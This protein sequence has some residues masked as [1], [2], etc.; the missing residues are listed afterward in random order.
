[1]HSEAGAGARA[2][3][4]LTHWVGGQSMDAVG[5]SKRYVDGGVGLEG[6]QG[7][8]VFTAAVRV[9]QHRWPS[10]W[11]YRYTG[12]KGWAR[13]RCWVCVAHD[14]HYAP[15]VTRS[16]PMVSHAGR[17]GRGH[18]RPSSWL[19]ARWLTFKTSITQNKPVRWH[20]KH[21]PSSIVQLSTG[22]GASPWRDSTKSAVDPRARSATPLE[23]AAE[24]TFGETMT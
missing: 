4:V 5:Q 16:I 18:V 1:M 12:F 14:N 21:G 24:E 10:V 9:R 13:W 23:E 15:Q 20:C 3:S 17:G 6:Q 2:G 22:S 7:G 11:G 8:Q 19:R